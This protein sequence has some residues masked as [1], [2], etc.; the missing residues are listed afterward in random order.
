MVRVWTL[1]VMLCAALAGTASAQDPRGAITGRVLDESGGH[2]PGATVTVKNVATNVTSTAITN[3]EGLYIVPPLTPG[4]YVVTVELV[5][6]KK[7]VREGVEVRVGYRLGLD[8]TLALGRVEETVSVTAESPL[9]ETLSGSTGQVID[10]KRIAMMPLSDGNPF[11]LA[12]LAPGIAYTGD[13]K[14]SRPFDNAGTSGITT[15]GATGGNEFTL[16]GSPNM[17]SGR[18]VAFACARRL[19]AGPAMVRP[20]A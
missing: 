1:V 16:D 3:R 4:I 6:F 2:V 12:R 13:L 15:G 19:G 9:L 20:S 17:A 10:E 7:S 18:R 14:F 8:F 5:G 11:V